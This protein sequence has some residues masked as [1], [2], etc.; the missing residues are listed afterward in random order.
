[1]IKGYVNIVTKISKAL[2]N[3]AAIILFLTAMLV[4]ANV[5]S[6][7]L[8]DTPIQGTHDF[9]LFLT[10]VLISLSIAYCAVKDGHISISVFMDRLP[11][12][13]QKVID[14]LIGII[15][16]IFLFFVTRNIILYAD[17][18]RQNGEVSLTI[19]LPHFPFVVILGIGFGLLGLVVIGKVLSLYT[20]EGDQ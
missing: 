15:S 13:V 7:R 20:K 14:S 6:R 8:F 11:R 2:E 18:M 1:M 12:K 4:L 19:G 9:I 17:E 3:I 16:A 5:L 10:P